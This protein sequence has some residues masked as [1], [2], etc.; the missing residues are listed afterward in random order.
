M[1]TSYS[2]VILACLVTIATSFALVIAGTNQSENARFQTASVLSAIDRRVEG[3]VGMAGNFLDNTTNDILFLQSLSKEGN[4]KQSWSEIGLKK[5]IEKNDSY[6]ELYLFDGSGAC[7]AYANRHGGISDGLCS[8][9]PEVIARATSYGSRLSPGEIFMSPLFAYKG[10][11]SLFYVAPTF[12]DKT[13]VAVISMETL[14]EDIRRLSRDG[15]SVFL[16]DATGSYLA[17]QDRSKEKLSGAT[18]DFYSDFRNVPSGALAN[19]D[20]KRIDTDKKT[21]SFWR[22]NSYERTHALY[23]GITKSN[24]NEQAL[25]QWILVDVSDKS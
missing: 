12:G 13:L 18:S 22:L 7:V 9:V 19:P 5:I 2:I 25:Y 21:F 1:R 23:E 17:H 15:D 4:T 16:V 11:S 3:A 6:E 10:A 14:F 20:I 8:G 24:M